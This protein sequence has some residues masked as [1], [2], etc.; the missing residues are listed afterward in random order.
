MSSPKPAG[1]LTKT[2]DLMQT[3][4]VTVPEEST[5]EEAATV[6]WERHIGSVIVVNKSGSMTGILTESD[7]IFAICKGLI[8]KNVTVK[9]IMSQT[10]LIASPNEGGATVLERMI[11]ANVRHLPVIDKDAR[12]LGMI[13]TRDLMGI[14]EPF[15]KFLLKAPSKKRRK[16]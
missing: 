7:M 12:P 14:T 15:L 10:S 13:S 1:S 11:K 6:L 3:P 5:L 4:A 16:K 9:S 2:R 8:G